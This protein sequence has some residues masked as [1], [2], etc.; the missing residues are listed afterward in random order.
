[1]E[2]EGCVSLGSFLDELEAKSRLLKR[3]ERQGDLGPTRT[4]A[5]R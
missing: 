1:M 4:M 2:Q 3:Q 5:F